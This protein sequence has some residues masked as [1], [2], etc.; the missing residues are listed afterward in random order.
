M[1]NSVCKRFSQCVASSTL[2]LHIPLVNPLEHSAQNS[3]LT[4]SGHERLGECAFKPRYNVELGRSATCSVS[5][6]ISATLASG[7]KTE[8][9]FRPFH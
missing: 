4:N 9:A 8:W 1:V 7:E 6:S 2:R 5:G 3:V